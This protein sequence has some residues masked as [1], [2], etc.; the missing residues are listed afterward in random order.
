MG[1]LDQWDCP[2]IFSFQSER[3]QQ[4]TFSTKGVQGLKKILITLLIV[5]IIVVAVVFYLAYSPNA[6]RRLVPVRSVS[7]QPGA[8]QE[9]TPYPLLPDTSIRNVILFIGDGMGINQI[10]VAR[11]MLFGPNGRLHLER[12][13]VTG[14]VSTHTAD[15]LITKSDA[16]ATAL[17]SGVKTRNGMIGMT[18]DSVK[19]LTIMEAA[20]D[21]GLSTGLITSSIITDATPAAFAAH[22]PARNM[23]GDIAVQL[24]DNRIDILLAGY[25]GYFIPKSQ[26]GSARTDEL[27]LIA[28]AKNEGYAFVETKEEFAAV[29]SDRLLG[30]F[31]PSSYFTDHAD[32]SLAELTEKAVETLNRNPHGFFLMVE[33]EN[34]DEGSHENELEYM[35][36]QLKL[37]DDAVKV[38]IDFALQDKQTL[39]LV[40]ADHETGGL[41]IDGGRINDNSIRVVWT[42]TSHTGQPIALFG[43]GPQVLRFTGLK[44]N[45]EIP[46]ILAGLLSIDSFPRRLD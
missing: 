28:R 39:V 29:K 9:I 3:N 25:K 34:I 19:M 30:L 33:Q 27:D 35:A 24:L 5:S 4:S 36:G 18:P 31:P 42:T 46:K 23:H 38:G 37:F 20:R 40:L 15:E 1:L 2:S 13:P 32:P 10:A 17:A 22:V 44:D 6:P 43:F 12:L 21:R 45:T 16:G 41:Q 8:V 26:E 11:T 14:L 7:Y